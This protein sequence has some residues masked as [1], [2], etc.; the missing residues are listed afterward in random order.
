[1]GWMKAD[2]TVI[3]PYC[4]QY[5]RL[6]ALPKFPDGKLWTGLMKCSNAE[7]KAASP[8]VSGISEEDARE[9]AINAAVREYAPPFRP[10]TLLEATESEYC[11]IELKNAESSEMSKFSTMGRVSY[12]DDPAKACIWRIGTNTPTSAQRHMYGLTWRCWARKPTPEERAAVT[13]EIIEDE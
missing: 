11:Y 3:C 8:I 12:D 6:M 7:C 2:G 1:M 10:L 9:K 5:M 4:G 13:W